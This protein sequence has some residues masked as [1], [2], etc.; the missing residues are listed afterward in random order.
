MGRKNKKNK[1]KADVFKYTH[2]MEKSTVIKSSWV[3]GI[4]QISKQQ[5][6][7]HSSQSESG[8]KLSPSPYFL[9]S[10]TR[11][12]ISTMQCTKYREQR[13]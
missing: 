4:L 12:I 13:Y 7:K 9:F 8:I 6:Y 1:S 3:C 2:C 10:S 11:G 5:R